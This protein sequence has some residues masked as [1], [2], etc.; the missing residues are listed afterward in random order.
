[1]IAAMPTMRVSANVVRVALF[2]S[3]LGQ[4]VSASLA[5]SRCDGELDRG[6]LAQKSMRHPG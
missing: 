3:R 5:E 2:R 4:L 6:V 1:M